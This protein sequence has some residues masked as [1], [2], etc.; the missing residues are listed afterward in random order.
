MDLFA[1]LHKSINAEG[2]IL[3]SASHE[4]HSAR[5]RLENAKRKIIE[6]L[7]NFIRKSDVKN[8]LQDSVWMLRDGRYVLPVR[9]D[10]KTEIDGIPRGVSQSGST[11]FIEPRSLAIQHTELEKAQSDVEIEEHRIIKELSK[12]C[13]LV[14][15]EILSSAEVLTE[16]D[17]INSR[18]KF[19]AAIVGVKP[20][21]LFATDKTLRFSLIN[22]KHPLFLLEKNIV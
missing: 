1:K 7:E 3:S 11:V 12:E 18:A 17:N 6:Q 4:L 22:A 20:N 10:R 5:N 21:F 2:Q 14:R 16:I 15:E 8:A 13:Y 9:A 19:A